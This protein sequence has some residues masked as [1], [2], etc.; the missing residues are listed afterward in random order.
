MSE[1]QTKSAPSRLE[2]IQN[3]IKKLYKVNKKFSITLIVLSIL[4]AF[5]QFSDTYSKPGD[6]TT[7]AQ[8]VA[9]T[10]SETTIIA[11][12]ATILVLAVI[13]AG[14]II[15][16][17]IAY[18]TYKAIDNKVPSISEAFEASQNKFWVILWLNVIIFFRVLG[19]IL[20]LIIPGIRAGLR[21]TIAPIV[22]FDENLSA[23][24]TANKSREIAKGNLNSLLIMNLVSAVLFPITYLVYYGSLV[25]MYP[26]FKSK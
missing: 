15:E 18:A 11:I 13:A 1:K 7:G 20:L 22:L 26:F 6:Q 24:D 2:L 16:G 10:S 8:D 19:G 17:M 5:S 25:T 4:S 3:G 21:Y 12:V 23:K 9:M 14:V